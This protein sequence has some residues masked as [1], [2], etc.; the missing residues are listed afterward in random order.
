MHKFL[1]A[2]FAYVVAL[3]SLAFFFWLIQFGMEQPNKIFAG[4]ALIQNLLIFILFPLQHSILPR[5]AVKK[6]ISRVL[7]EELERSFYVLTSGIVMWVAL[8]NWQNFGPYIYRFEFRLVFDVI[9][10]VALVLIIAATFALNHS[11]MFGLKQGYAAWRRQ[12]LPDSGLQTNGLY[13]VVRHPITSLLLIA[14]WS[15]HTLT[16]GRLMFNLLFSAYALAGTWF[17]E[18]D[19]IKLFGDKYL[20]YKRK[21]PA[22]VPRLGG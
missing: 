12:R 15:H 19:L 5:Q 13:R 1:F 22:F 11:M 14:L 18:R 6:F 20:E 16:A 2:V 17:E 21:V 10:Y 3:T 7:G 9:F 8:L 4:A